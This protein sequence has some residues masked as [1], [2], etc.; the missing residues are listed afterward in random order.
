[1]RMPTLLVFLLLLP[2]PTA[3]VGMEEEI[4]HLL[5]YVE[6]SGCTFVRNGKEHTA[7]E[8]REHIAMKYDHVKKRVKSTEDFIKYAASK[9]SLSGKPYT[10]RCG[11]EEMPTAGWLSAELAR[12]RQPGGEDT[13]LKSHDERSSP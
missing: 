8:G 13:M 7:A 1:M 2:V 4:A 12:F 6:A 9:S 11:D 10:V 5:L 3:A